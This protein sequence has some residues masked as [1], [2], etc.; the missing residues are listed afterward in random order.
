MK[1]L[2]ILLVI[3]SF[4]VFTAQAQSTNNTTPSPTKVSQVN[5]NESVQSVNKTV[6]AST[7]A[8]NGQQQ[9]L[10]GNH[11][12]CCAHSGNQVNKKSCCSGQG[13]KGKNCNKDQGKKEDD[14]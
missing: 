3:I 2:S 7:G 6:P 14:Q 8:V 5:P 4:A 10:Q 13:N 1:K 11:K 12:S 9:S